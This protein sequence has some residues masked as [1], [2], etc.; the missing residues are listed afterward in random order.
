MEKFN[1]PA[2]PHF[3]DVFY[4]MIKA[5]KKATYAILSLSDIL[6]E[7]WLVAFIEAE[8]LINSRPLT[9]VSAKLQRQHTTD[10]EPLLISSGG[11]SVCSV[12][13]R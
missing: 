2:A 3:G 4:C 9:T 5:A 6:D 10:A 12:G 11:W 8:S 13:C 1:L 7:E